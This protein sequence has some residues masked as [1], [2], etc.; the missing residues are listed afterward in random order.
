[1]NYLPGWVGGL[2]CGKDGVSDRGKYG[3]L[4]KVRLRK[5]QLARLMELCC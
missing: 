3:V 2:D 4:V 5:E 1:M